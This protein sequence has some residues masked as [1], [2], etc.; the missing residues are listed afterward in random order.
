MDVCE[1]LE[2][3]NCE[4]HREFV[5]RLHQS[6]IAHV[7]NYRHLK[8]RVPEA[9]RSERLYNADVWMGDEAVSL[10]YCNKA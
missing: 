6:F 5:A 9:E 4:R 8:L 2:D 7:E 10:G 3:Q 1:P